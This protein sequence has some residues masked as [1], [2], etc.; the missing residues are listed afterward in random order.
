M[1]ELPVSGRTAIL[2]RG[3]GRDLRLAARHADPAKDSFGF[4]LALVARLALIDGAP[5]VPEDLD[6][7]DLEDV[8]ALMSGLPGKSLLPATS[9]P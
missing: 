9:S 4:S 5:V 8:M 3:Q 1:V 2:R 6:E 7:M